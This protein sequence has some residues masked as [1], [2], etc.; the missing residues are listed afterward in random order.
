MKQETRIIPEEVPAKFYAQ[1][2]KPYEFIKE[3]ATGKRVLEVGCGDGYGSAYLAKVAAEVIGIDYEQDVIAQAQGKYRAPNL[4]FLYMP[5]TELEF[6]DNSFDIICAFQVI[7]HILE[8]KLLQFLSEV[9]RVLKEEGRFYLST[10]N[11]EHALKSALTYKKNPAH[12]KEFRLKELS[13][14]LLQIFPKVEIYGLHLTAKHAFYLCLK[15]SGICNFLPEAIN[16][17]ARFYHNVTLADFKITANNLS[18]ASDFI[19]RCK[20][21][22]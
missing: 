18:K 16:L 19:C 22:I 12:C 2:L 3:E 4:S 14:L 21:A 6:R 9:K 17:V 11:L 7:E 8:E 20:K 5:A 13:D 10:L 15:R 1:H